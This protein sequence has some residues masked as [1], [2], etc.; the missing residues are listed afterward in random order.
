MA[1]NGRA[2]LE[3]AGRGVPS[4]RESAIQE[5]VC[6]WLMVPHGDREDRTQ[7]GCV[8]REEEQSVGSEDHVVGVFVLGNGLDRND[9]WFTRTGP[10][11]NLFKGLELRGFNLKIFHT[12]QRT[13]GS[14]RRQ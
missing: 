3:L 8:E 4:V 6:S 2:A 7:S 10:S 9:A 5:L 1:K 11:K 14:G 13:A 12:S